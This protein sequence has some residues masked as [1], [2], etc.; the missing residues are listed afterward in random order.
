M[1]L[2]LAMLT[3][4]APD[5]SQHVATQRK[6]YG[7]AIADLAV[8]VEPPFVV[9]GDAG[10]RQ[11]QQSAE[12]TVRW[13]VKHLEAEF[14]ARQPAAIYDIFLF[15]DATSY[16]AH[17]KA[18]WNESPGTPYGY[19]SSEH[20]ALVMN[21]AT[22][23]GTLVHELVHPY[24]AANFPAVPTWLNEGLASLFEQS[25]ERDGK[26]IGRTNWRLAGL[27]EGLKNRQVLPFAK[28]VA[29]TDATFRDDDEA[30]HYAQARYLMLYLQ[31]QQLLRP[32]IRRVLEQ[33]R[34][35]PTGG[36]ALRQTLGEEGWKRLDA[37]F[38]KWVPTLKFP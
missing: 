11:V 26:M 15:R 12:Q 38:C 32:F 14:F 20:R 1:L 13:A 37:A 33:Q 16:Q 30:V 35:D 9:W 27:N 21:I 29:T 8:V 17:A 3:A 23:G 34:T 2:I 25:D 24:F 7:A 28:L 19:A 36:T 10:D 6:K 5:Y 18:M 31:E 4:A 22:G